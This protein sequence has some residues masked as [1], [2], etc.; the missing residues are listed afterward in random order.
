MLDD[1]RVVEAVRFIE[2]PF[3]GQPSLEEIA[4]RAELSP[5]HFQRYFKKAMGESPASYSRRIRLDR[6]ALHL[7]AT[8]KVVAEIAFM[9]GYSSHEAFVRAFHG[10]FGRVPS[11]YRHRARRSVSVPTAGE[12]ARVAQIRLLEFGA[13]PLLAMRFYGPYANVEAHWLHFVEALRQCGIDPGTC[14]AV[15]IAY[16]SPEIVDNDFIRYDCAIVASD[17]VRP[18]SA[19][20]RLSLIPGAYGALEHRAPYNTIFSTYRVISTAWLPTLAGKLRMDLTCAYEFYRKPPW[21]N[22][23]GDQHFDLMLPVAWQEMAS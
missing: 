13:I 17:I 10:Q 8:N 6:A 15:G 4:A 7:W 23:G 14:Q 22:V 21:C 3:D 9:S 19:L 11:D 2:Q 20:F 16:D 5:H 12:M 18:R 1:W